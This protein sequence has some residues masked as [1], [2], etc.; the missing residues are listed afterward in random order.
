MTSARA[1]KVFSDRTRRWKHEFEAKREPSTASRRKT[2]GRQEARS[3]YCMLGLL[4]WCFGAFRELSFRRGDTV[5]ILQQI[6]RNW[7]E[8]ERNGVRGIF[9]LNYV[10]VSP[11]PLHP[12]HHTL[13]QCPFSVLCDVMQV[14]T[15]LEEAYARAEERE[16]EARARYTFNAQTDLELSLKKVCTDIANSAT[17]T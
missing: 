14:L 10:E 4:L 17:R 1:R 6:D 11:H 16:G 13:T 9:P 8:G 2:D 3:F 7:C 12:H 5:Y 15:S